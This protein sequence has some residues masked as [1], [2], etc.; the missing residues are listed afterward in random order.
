MARKENDTTMKRVLLK[1][2]PCEREVVFSGVDGDHVLVNVFGDFSFTRRIYLPAGT[3]DL[4]HFFARLAKKSLQAWEGP[5]KYTSIE[6]D[7]SI[8]VNCTTRG[9]V[10]FSFELSDI[11]QFERRLADMV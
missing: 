6:G 5:E 1:S 9:H 4:E 8:E 2:S 3:R 7:F 11:S 10:I